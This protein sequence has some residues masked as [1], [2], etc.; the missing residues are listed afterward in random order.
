[1]ATEFA[2]HKEWIKINEAHFY[3]IP[4]SSTVHCQST[5]FITLC[6][7]IHTVNEFVVHAEHT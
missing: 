6:A 7:P 3:H 2:Q 4:N 1:M 5:D